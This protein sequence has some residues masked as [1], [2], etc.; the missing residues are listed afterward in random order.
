MGTLKRILF[1]EGKRLIRENDYSRKL[2]I[3][4]KGKVRV[5]K[6]YMGGKITLAILGAGEIF[7]ELSFFDSKPR[8]ASVETI[9]EVDAIVIDGDALTDDIAALPKWV[10]LIFRSVATRFREIDQKMTVLQSLNQF[11]RKTMSKDSAGD[12]IYS[13]LLR[14]TKILKMIIH[15]NGN[16]QSK[17]FFQKELSLTLG[18]SYISDKAFLRMLFEYNYVSG[19][20]F[21]NR[22]EYDFDI[23]GL[24]E[25]EDF[26]RNNFENDTCTVLSHHALS[27]MRKI[28][29]FMDLK[30]ENPGDKPLKLSEESI[31]IDPEDRDQ[32][33]AHAQLKKLKMITVQTDGTYIFPEHFLSHF[34]YF[35]IVKTFDHTIIYE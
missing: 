24:T 5:Y 15:E 9:S 33:A 10:H 3:L 23:E 34:K 30:Q 26:L 4:K 1:N 2:Y 22:K 13:D 32:N 25:F 12:T 7:G 21:E 19:E 20:V 31:K 35:S 18:D 29:T 8:S 14:M 27:L 17:D 6:E 28:I 11:Q 16:S